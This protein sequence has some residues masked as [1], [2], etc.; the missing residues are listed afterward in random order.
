MPH[1]KIVTPSDNIIT[2][3]NMTKIHFDTN[4]VSLNLVLR[5]CTTTINLDN[6]KT[7]REQGESKL[8]VITIPTAKK[9]TRLD[10]QFNSS[11]KK[12]P[13]YMRSAIHNINRYIPNKI[14]VILTKDTIVPKAL[15]LSKPFIKDT[16]CYVIDRKLVME[17][18]MERT[19]KN[20]CSSLLIN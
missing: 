13:P 11:N 5:G 9:H 4:C 2:E 10:V 3:Q 19:K 17:I 8:K 6:D 18:A 7:K 15:D 14:S 20:T 16:L 1:N 12:F